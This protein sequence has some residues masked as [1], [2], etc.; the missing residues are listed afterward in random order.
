[1]VGVYGRSVWE[2]CTRGVYGRECMGGVHERSVREEC[3][4]SLSLRSHNEPAHLSP[5][6][7]AHVRIS[8][9]G[10]SPGNPLTRVDAPSPSGPSRRNGHFGG[11]RSSKTINRI[12][13]GTI[14]WWWVDFKR[15]K[16]GK[17][18]MQYQ[19]LV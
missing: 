13:D 6:P 12:G 15:R 18:A 1:M 11:E 14:T 5:A 2:E 19:Y 4:L 17:E 3:V 8:G 9:R 7:S 16:V 10:S